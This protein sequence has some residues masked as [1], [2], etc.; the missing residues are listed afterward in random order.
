[1][2]RILFLFICALCITSCNPLRKF[3]GKTDADYASTITQEDLKKHLNIYASDEFAGRD[4]GEE[5]AKVAV[6]YLVTQYAA[7]GIGAPNDDHTQDVKLKRVKPKQASLTIGE[8][9]FTLGEEFV[10][11]FTVDDGKMAGSDFVY[12]GYGI[13]TDEFSSFDDVD[14]EGKIVV[15]TLGEPMLTDS[16]FVFSGTTDASPWS[17]VRASYRA[18][19]GAAQKRG[20][21]SMILLLP[22]DMYENYRG[23]FN[24]GGQERMMLD[25]VGEPNSF[26]SFFAGAAMEAEILG[27][28]AKDKATTIEKPISI[29]YENEVI[30][31][32]AEN[33]VAHIKGS[34][35]P[36]EYVVISAHLDHVGVNEEGEIYNG[37]DDDGSGTVG[38]LEIAEAFQLA[39]TEGHRPKRS[40]LFLH[41]TGEEKGLL[42]S[43][44]YTDHDP[45]IPLE[46]TVTNLNIDMI[47]RIDP[48]REGNRNY[49]YLIGSDK[50][51]QELHDLSETVNERTMNIELDYTYNAEDDPN[52]FYYRSDHYNFAK[53]NIPI[54]FYFNGTH[55]DYHQPSDTVDKIEWDLLQNRTQLVFYTAWAVANRESRIVVDLLEE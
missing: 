42:G 40:V 36:N 2:N 11:F 13:E 43:Q 22:D 28:N 4:T 10:N 23:R 17:S 24:E 21:T 49:I 55:D 6:N 15:A 34:E 37:A 5:S 38:V 19:V 44:Y 30:P 31:F 26:Y 51:S 8:S 25:V 1:M 7:M 16:T 27:E 41:V 48:E 12:V 53:N 14:V 54:I 18:R 33:V 3:A 35:L 39:A 29:E 46:N 9:N 45:I 52:R 50:L 32:I 20:A 47:G